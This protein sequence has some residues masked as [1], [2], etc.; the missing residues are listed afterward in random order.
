[1]LGKYSR[2]AYS[3]NEGRA[4]SDG[5]MEAAVTCKIERSKIFRLVARVVWR[6]KLFR[7]SGPLE[8]PAR[9]TSRETH[10]NVIC[11]LLLNIQPVELLV[12][13]LKSL[14]IHP[15]EKESWE[16]PGKRWTGEGGHIDDF[17]Q[18]V[19]I[20]RAKR[21]QKCR[22]NRKIKMRNKR[23]D[24]LLIR[25]DRYLHSYEGTS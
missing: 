16:S 14:C 3:A 20:V 23:S 17:M 5:I 4:A 21:R 9:V 1:M 6:A 7:S 13:I 12:C 2:S 8:A 18:T 25:L 15:C 19:A 10:L 11:E 22:G 24:T